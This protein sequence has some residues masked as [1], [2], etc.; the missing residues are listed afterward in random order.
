MAGTVYVGLDA[1]VSF[2]SFKGR[3]E[4]TRTAKVGKVVKVVTSK[5]VFEDDTDFTVTLGEDRY[6]QDQVNQ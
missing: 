1:V 3:L 6:S 5:H 2:K 4:L